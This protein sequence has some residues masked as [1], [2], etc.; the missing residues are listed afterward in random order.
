MAVS[1]VSLSDRPA[2]D[3]TRKPILRPP[4]RADSLFQF[5]ISTLL[6]ATTLIAACLAAT[7]A[8]PWV[9]FPL[10]LVA[11]LAF[12]RTSMTRRFY[13]E[14][15]V[16][17]D[18]DQQLVEFAVSCA[19]IVIA[20]VAAGV[21]LLGVGMMG[22]AIGDCLREHA[23]TASVIIFLASMLL[24]AVTSAFTFVGVLWVTRPR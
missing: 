10:S 19:L 21:S 6:V 22:A 23:R 15:C 11:L 24:A 3:G 12:V 18:F 16:P 7:L 20:F 2:A 4:R 8:N 14:H 9:G 1:G 13:R 5:S 17:F